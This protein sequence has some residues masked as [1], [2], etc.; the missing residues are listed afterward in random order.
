MTSIILVR[1]GQTEWNRVERFR[2]RVDLPLNAT[3]RSQAH[4]AARRILST[5]NIAAVYTSPLQRAV[6]TAQAIGQR[7]A[8]PVTKCPGLIDID[9]GEWQG[10]TPE[11]VHQ[12]YPELYSLWLTSP[13]RV[14]IPGGESLGRVRRRAMAAIREI[15]ARHPQE[16]VVL[17]SHLVVC[18][19]LVL[20]MLGLPTACFWHIQQDTATI[21]VFEHTDGR[22]IVKVIND[23][24][25]LREQNRST[26]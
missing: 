11:E 2:G 24:C 8:V 1:H 5:W 22:F 20:A 9:Y 18:R 14:R 26:S 19:L 23:T 6:E 15:V 4:A 21:N 17:V 25:H 3:G 16:T 13:Q 12:Q 7:S 10:L